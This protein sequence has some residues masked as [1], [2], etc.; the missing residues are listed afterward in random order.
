MTRTPVRIWEQ[1][2][3]HVQVS[4]GNVFYTYTRGSADSG[5]IA[6]M[7]RS[8]EQILK[9]RP[10]EKIGYLFHVVAGASPPSSEDRERVTE[11]FN[12]HASRLSGVAVVVE[13]AGFSGAMLRSAVTMVFVMTRRGFESRTFEDV[14]MAAGWR[15]P[16]VGMPAGEIVRLAGEARPPAPSASRSA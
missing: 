5:R 1:D 4:F 16:R 10:S 11:M 12:K 3:S 8:L 7:V 14:H 9:E 13:A 15:A 6:S 2:D